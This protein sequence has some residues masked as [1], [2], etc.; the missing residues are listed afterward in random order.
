MN[1]SVIYLFIFLI[2]LSSALAVSISTNA[3][4]Y[5]TPSL[6]TISISDCSGNSILRILADGELVDIKNGNGNWETVYNTESSSYDGIY[7]LKA[8]CTNG[9][10]E[11]PICVDSPGCIVPTPTPS[12]GGSG[13][14][15]R[16]TSSWSCST[17]TLCNAS[18]E[19]TRACYDTKNCQS[20]KVEVRECDKCQESWV[21]SLWGSC[22]NGVQRR[23]CID[24]HFCETTFVKPLEQKNCDQTVVGGNQPAQIDNTLPP[25]NVAPPAPVQAGFSFSQFWEKYSTYILIGGIIFILIIILVLVI[26]HFVKPKRLAYNHADLVSWMNKEK[27]MGTSDTELRNILSQRTGWNEEEINEAFEELSASKTPTNYSSEN[28]TPTYSS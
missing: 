27:S 23:N 17:W 5:S 3:D 25:P 24:Q 10:A 22:S 1:K 11:K 26:A 15:S 14:G 21:C 19:Q 6:A 18:L 2:F 8:S 28:V 4:E 9:D 20:N 13:G 7:Q 12:P 16:C